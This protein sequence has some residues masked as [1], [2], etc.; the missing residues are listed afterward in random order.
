MECSLKSMAVLERLGDTLENNYFLLKD[1]GGHNLKKLLD[2]VSSTELSTNNRK[3]L[4]DYNPKGVNLRYVFE[5]LLT[6]PG[7]VLPF[8]EQETNIDLSDK[9]MDEAFGLA[10][11][12]SE[13]ARAAYKIV[14]PSTQIK[15]EE[16]ETRDSVI[17]CYNT[18]A[19]K[20]LKP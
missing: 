4:I 15:L 13:I 11:E 6:D 17:E 9:R 7:S 8:P 2:L 5:I 16:G 18:A 1:K 12:V 19:S 14:F 20:I 10:E 3:K